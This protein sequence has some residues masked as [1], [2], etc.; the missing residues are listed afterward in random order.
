MIDTVWLYLH[1]GLNINHLYQTDNTFPYQTV[2]VVFVS[3]R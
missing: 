1:G 2:T 3:F